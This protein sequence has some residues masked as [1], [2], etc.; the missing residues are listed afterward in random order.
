MKNKKGTRIVLILII[1]ILI[2]GAV[3]LFLNRDTSLSSKEL[4]RIA[5]AH[6]LTYNSINDLA[7]NE[8][9]YS[10]VNDGTQNIVID[11]TRLKTVDVAKENYKNSKELIL[12]YT[13][14]TENDGKETNEK[15][16]DKFELEIEGEYYCTIRTRKISNTT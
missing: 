6:G 16:K 5:S 14:K 2:V 13:G 9:E 3:L 8:A 11:Y 4:E 7:E 10:K 15:N 12:Q 1:V